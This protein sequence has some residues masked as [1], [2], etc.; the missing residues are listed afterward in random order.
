MEKQTKP[1]KHLR[2]VIDT[3]LS[4]SQFQQPEVTDEVIAELRSLKQSIIESGL[5]KYAP[6]KE[7]SFHDKVVFAI[8]ILSLKAQQ[9][10]K[11]QPSDDSNE[12]LQNGRHYLMGVE[13]KDLTVEDALEAFGFGRNGLKD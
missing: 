13:P 11:E 10:E 7:M 5:L 9:P 1:Q 2:K 6:R 3:I 12:R 8:S 4:A